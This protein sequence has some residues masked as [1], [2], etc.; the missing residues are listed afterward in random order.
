MIHPNGAISIIDRKK[1][2]FKLQ[3][4][5][6]IAPEKLENIYGSSKYVQQIFVHGDSLKTSIVAIIVIDPETLK[7]W[8]EKQGNLIIIT[9]TKLGYDESVDQ[10]IN[11]ED[12][13]QTVN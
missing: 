5:E 2:I 6:Y 8:G 11:R 9:A 3:Q 1:H 13:I 12:F 10:M 4:G 7:A